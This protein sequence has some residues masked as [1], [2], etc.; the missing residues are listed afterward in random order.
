[1]ALPSEHGL[2]DRYESMAYSHRL[3]V[4]SAFFCFHEGVSF[5]EK[6]WQL[7]AAFTRREMWKIGS[8]TTWA[9]SRVRLAV[10]AVPNSGAAS[11]LLRK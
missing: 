1:M 3:I 7:R 10:D 4:A 2:Q 8:Y 6:S 9:K 11:N 5:G